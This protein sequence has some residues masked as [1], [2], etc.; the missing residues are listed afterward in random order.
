MSTLTLRAERQKRQ[1]LQMTAEPDL[2]Q[3]A[4]ICTHMATVEVK[5]L[6]GKWLRKITWQTALC[7]LHVCLSVSKL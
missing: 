7:H 1:K 3:D 5:Q 6:K 2:A 4:S